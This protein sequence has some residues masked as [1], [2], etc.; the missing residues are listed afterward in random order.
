MCS[1]VLALGITE[2]IPDYHQ[3]DVNRARRTPLSDLVQMR[4]NRARGGAAV[5]LKKADDK[6]KRLSLL[7]DLQKSPLL[8][9]RQ[10]KWAREEVGRLR[11]GIE[12]EKDSAFFLGRYF[13]GG[14]NH[15]L[16]HDLRLEFEGDVA[17]I[18]HLVINRLGRFYLIETKNYAGNVS[19]NAHGEFTVEYDDD[20]FGVPSPIEQSHRHERVLR[21]LLERLEIS[22]RLGTSL[23]FHHVV[24]FHP[25]AIITRPLASEFDTSCVI[26][27]D[28]FP[29]WHR[30]FVDTNLG[31]GT[32]LRGVANVRSLETAKEWGEKLVRQHR[33]ANQLD[34]PEFMRPHEAARP[35][36]REANPA[37]QVLSAPTASIGSESA[38]RLVCLHCGAKIS[39][40]EGRYCWNNEARFKGGQ[41]CREHQAVF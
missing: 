34:L 35:A 8:D 15:V 2:R 39:F 26:K 7:I 27:A 29:S 28:Q 10:K 6:S 16:L 13:K 3:A 21:R 33:V 11:K 12:G 32:V 25:K 17:Q 31:I 14:E 22:N 18:D 24:M 4:Q 36:S 19:I 30:R 41:Y 20:R 1:G 37:A 38:K 9:A 40:A 23:D 5:F